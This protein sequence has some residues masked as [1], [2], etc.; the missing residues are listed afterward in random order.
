MGRNV[1]SG[2]S[3]NPAYTPRREFWWEQIPDIG[4]VQNCIPILAFLK[5]VPRD[6]L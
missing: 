5:D 4:D 1:I 6:V 2:C 3:E